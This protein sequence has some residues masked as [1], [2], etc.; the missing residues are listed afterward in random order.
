MSLKMKNAPRRVRIHYGAESRNRTG[1]MFPPRDFES[2]ASTY[3]AI[4]AAQES[5]ITDFA[6]QCNRV[7]EFTLLPGLPPDCQLLICGR[8]IAY[9]NHSRRRTGGKNQ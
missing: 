3:S 7:I 5:I 4:S 8:I 9:R 6:P 1:T 2:R